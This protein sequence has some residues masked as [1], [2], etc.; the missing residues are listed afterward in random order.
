MVCVVELLNRRPNRVSSRVRRLLAW[1]REYVARLAVGHFAALV[2]ALAVSI[3]LRRP[4]VPMDG[5][6]VLPI[7]PQ[8]LIVVFFWLA[9]LQVAGAFEPRSLSVGA[10]EFKRITRA[11]GRTLACMAIVGLVF[12]LQLS[13]WLLA[14]LLPVGYLLLI[15]SSLACRRWIHGRRLAG[16]A[17]YSILAVGS[18]VSVEQLVHELQYA[19]FAG[20]RVV[21]ACVPEE[22]GSHGLA[23]GTPVLGAPDEA[24]AQAERHAIDVVATT[25]SSG[26]PGSYLR[27][28][29]WQLEGSGRKLLV[30]PGMANMAGPRITMIPVAGVPLVWVDEPEFT[31][32]RRAAKRT[33][34]V[35]AASLLL[36][37]V[38]PLLLITAAAIKLDSRGSV[39][40]RQLRTGLHGEPF[41]VWKFRSM[42]S[43]AEDLRAAMDQHNESDGHLFKM[44]SDPRVT[45]VGKIIRRT[46][47]D[48]LPQLFNVLHGNM[49]LVGPRPLPVADS[50]Y[51]GSARRRLLVVPGITGLWQVQ[52][53]SNT[54]W[55]EAM[56]LDL[57]YV[58]NWSLSLDLVILARTVIAVVRGDGAY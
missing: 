2:A 25:G 12:D 22:E 58:E 6:D 45:R 27:Q 51:S 47:V 21:G 30:A 9:M 49:S 8:G 17:S 31:G 15:A 54:T 32:F 40:F 1:E 18:R 23:S 44:S 55:E 11:T 36:V 20:L 14:I 24:A 37:L 57:Y 50:N 46:S 43:N 39:F 48:E 33:I 19:P 26:L 16:E 4:I 7:W 29:G 5:P 52:G 53:R 34:D 38:S 13:R 3:W 28:L 10:E 56:R 41:R 42:L 35:V